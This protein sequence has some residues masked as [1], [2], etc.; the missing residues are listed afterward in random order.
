MQ[1]VVRLGRARIE[2]INNRHIVVQK[3]NAKARP[4]MAP[5]MRRDDDGSQLQEGNG[6][7]CREKKPGAAKPLR[8]P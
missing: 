8:A 1:D 7:V 5:E 2:D 6:H 3:L 4:R